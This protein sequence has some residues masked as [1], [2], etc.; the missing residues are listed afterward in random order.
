MSES[1]V[2][3]TVMDVLDNHF[4]TEELVTEENVIDRISD[5]ISEN[6]SLYKENERL[7]EDIEDMSENL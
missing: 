4:V 5:L 1:I 2:L 6:D 3:E 7:T